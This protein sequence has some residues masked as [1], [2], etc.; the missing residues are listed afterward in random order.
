MTTP[1]PGF[2]LPF[3]GSDEPDVPRLPVQR[4]AATPR[5]ADALDVNLDDCELLDEVELT[6]GLMLAA[7]ESPVALTQEEIDEVLGI[8][9]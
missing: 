9:S 6:V 5:V 4:T 2:G 3:S 1:I 7:N 8:A